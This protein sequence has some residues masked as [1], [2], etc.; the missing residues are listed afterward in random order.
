[1][2]KESDLIFARIKSGFGRQMDDIIEK[3]IEKKK[4]LGVTNGWIAENSGVPEQTV[5]KVMNGTTK[6]PGTAT[7]N[8]M[9]AALGISIDTGEDIRQPEVSPTDKYI[10]M[11][12][13]S[14]KNQLASKDEN[15]RAQLKHR[16]K[17]IVVLAIALAVVIL[18]EFTVLL[19]DITNLDRGWIRSMW[20]NG[21]I[22]NTI[23]EAIETAK[24]Y[25]G[26]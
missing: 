1:M 16:D 13:A 5:A 24:G 17:W 10:D 7:L 22:R 4:E 14:Y 19:Y 9:A 20:A 12:I 23:G 21:N 3:L 15:Y 6:N 8:P 2:Q 25:F 11:L 18:L 26:L